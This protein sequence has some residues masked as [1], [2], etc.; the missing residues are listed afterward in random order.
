MESDG[1]KKIQMLSKATIA[2][3]KRLR[4]INARALERLAQ[5]QINV[6]SAYIK[7][8]MKQFQKLSGAKGARLQPADASFRHVYGAFA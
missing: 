8:N 4:E 1:V 7:G 6:T 3:V 5:H 2:S